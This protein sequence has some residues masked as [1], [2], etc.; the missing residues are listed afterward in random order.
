MKEKAQKLVDIRIFEPVHQDNEWT[1]PTFYI[2]K[3]HHT[4]RT[5]SDLHKLN[6]SIHQKPLPQ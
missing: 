5:I 3:K 4:I 1:S 2:P 6:E